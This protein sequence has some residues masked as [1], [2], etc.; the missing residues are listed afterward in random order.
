MYEGL[1]LGLGSSPFVGFLCILR[2]C[3]FERR[4]WEALCPP[5]C[6]IWKFCE[7]ARLQDYCSACRCQQRHGTANSINVP[8]LLRQACCRTR[9]GSNN[10]KRPHHNRNTYCY[11]QYVSAWVVGG[12]SEQHSYRAHDKRANTGL[13]CVNVQPWCRGHCLNIRRLGHPYMVKVT[14]QHA[15]DSSLGWG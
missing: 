1:G 12:C 15:L 6:V 5:G 7:S 8:Q 10:H 2:F 4:G 14:S 3:Q 13:Q 9:V 11:F